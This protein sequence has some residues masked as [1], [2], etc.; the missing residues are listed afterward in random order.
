MLRSRNLRRTMI[1][2]LLGTISSEKLGIAQG[3]LPLAGAGDSVVIK[4]DAL[5]VIDPHKYRIPLSIECIQTVTLVAPFDG[6]VKQVVLKAN[7]KGQGQSEVVRLDNSMQKLHLA[8]AQFAQKIA[9]LELKAAGKEESAVAMAQAKVDLAKADVEIVEA[10]VDQTSIRMPFAGEIQR[11]LVT[12]GQFVRA[13]DSIAI[14][15]DSSKMKVEIPLDRAAAEVGKTMGIKIESNEVEGKIEAVLPLPPK[16][17]PLRELFDSI[18]SVSVVFENGDGK[19]KVGQT[20]YVPLIPRQPVAEVPV[21]AIGK[22]P[23]S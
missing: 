23:R 11:V 4:R 12:E 14:V 19:L 16:F 17:D 20:V 13:G 6:K 5:R 21:S 9:N 2:V 10:L 7:G 15:A 18:A 3:N 8:R 1:A 22:T